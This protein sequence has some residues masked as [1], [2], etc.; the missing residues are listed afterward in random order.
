MDLPVDRQRQNIAPEAG[1]VTTNQLIEKR[2][3]CPYCWESFTL[4]IDA[5]V[6]SQ[7]YIEDCQVC[8]HPIDFM[9][10][11]DEQNQPRVQI[12]QVDE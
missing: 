5:S 10:Q 7:E 9:I 11:L 8:C 6:E 2:V 1:T 4:L 12:R 3:Q